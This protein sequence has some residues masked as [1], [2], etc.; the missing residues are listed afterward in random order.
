LE[1]LSRPILIPNLRFYS[2]SIF[3]CGYGVPIT[4]ESLENNNVGGIVMWTA[5]NDGSANGLGIFDGRQLHQKDH[6]L[7]HLVIQKKKNKPRD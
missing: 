1:R 4:I 2:T 7:T 5:N 3:L 6:H